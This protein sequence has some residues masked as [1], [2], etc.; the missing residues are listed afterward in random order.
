M[1]G[2]AASEASSFDPLVRR[3]DWGRPNHDGHEDSSI[4][5]FSYDPNEVVVPALTAHTALS[6]GLSRPRRRRDGAGRF[7]PRS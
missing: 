1:E 7:L 6:A 5:E 3:G 4:E 2:Y